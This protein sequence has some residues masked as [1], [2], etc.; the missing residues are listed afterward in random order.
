MIETTGSPLLPF[1]PNL[2]EIA[3]IYHSKKIF[4]K[5]HLKGV[6]AI[7]LLFPL[8]DKDSDPFEKY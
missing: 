2:V 6:F 5:D 4:L 1:V 7:L 8:E 3:G